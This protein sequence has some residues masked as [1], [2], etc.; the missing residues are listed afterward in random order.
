MKYIRELETPCLILDK[1]LLS[2]NCQMFRNRCND[3]NVS[4]RPHVKTPKSVEIA[5]I[6]HGNKIGPITV[7]TLNEAEYFAKAGFTDIIYAVC[8][9][10]N[11]LS[12]I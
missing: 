9:V 2:K 10:P 8:V 6:A 12:R 1:K 7:S 11:K 3:L 4:L 5:K